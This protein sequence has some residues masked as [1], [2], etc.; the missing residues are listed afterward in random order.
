MTSRSLAFCLK[1]AGFLGRVIDT[2]DLTT[3]SAILLELPK[4]CRFILVLYVFAPKFQRI[5]WNVDPLNQNSAFLRLE[6]FAPT[7]FAPFVVVLSLQ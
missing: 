2:A 5:Y 7:S 4:N 6:E 3:A 1:S